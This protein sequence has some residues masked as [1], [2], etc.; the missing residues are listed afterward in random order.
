M[1]SIIMTSGPKFSEKNEKGERKA[2][3]L[4]NENLLETLKN[5][6]K[7]YN[8]LLFICSTPDNY[9]T[10]EEF[11]KII[12]KS[13]S[14]SGF[15]FQMSD[16]I[17]SRNWLFSKSLICNADLIIL[18]GGDPIEQ[19]EFFNNIELKEKLKKYNGCLLGISAGTINMASQAYCSKDEKIENTLYYK[20]LGLT[21]INIEPHF[22]ID[23]NKRIEE[24]L[25]QDSKKK[26]FLAIPDESF[27]LI[28]KDKIKLLGEGYYFSAGQYKKI[29][30]DEF[31]NLYGKNDKR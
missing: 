19:M 29:D 3:K 4:V 28:K 13:L 18:L 24:I 10:N 27:V 8:N 7:A 22:D 17:D 23:D 20:G 6:I 21:N 30:N 2:I 31:V 15:K 26:P 16:L 11:S 9:K 1:N 14:L 25:L 12:E 5:E